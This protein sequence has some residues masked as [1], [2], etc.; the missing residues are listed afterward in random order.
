VR[1]IAYDAVAGPR[2]FEALAR[3]VEDVKLRVPIAAAYPLDRAAEAHARLERG[4]VV[5]RIALRIHER[6]E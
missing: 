5:G 1:V 2:P 6:E 3:A 4:H